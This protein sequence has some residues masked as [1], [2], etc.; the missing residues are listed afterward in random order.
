M[1]IIFYQSE[2]TNK[3]RRNTA[4][5]DISSI[6]SEKNFADIDCVINSNLSLL[7]WNSWEKNHFHWIWFHWYTYYSRNDIY[8]IVHL[9]FILNWKKTIWICI[10]YSILTPL[11]IEFKFHCMICYM[12]IFHKTQTYSWLLNRLFVESIFNLIPRVKK[13]KSCNLVEMKLIFK[14]N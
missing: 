12:K 14:L 3:W 9:Y 7:H 11:I 8:A 10:D 1:F 2:Y 5:V 4:L 13:I 6:S